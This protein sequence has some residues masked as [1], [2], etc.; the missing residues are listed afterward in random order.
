APETTIVQADTIL[1][2]YNPNENKLTIDVKDKGLA[3]VTKKITSKSDKNIVLSPGLGS[4][5]VSGFVLNMDFA[6]ALE[7]FAYSNDM[8]VEAS[9]DDVFRIKL[10][11]VAE[12]EAQENKPL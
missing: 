9:G 8:V 10:K 1:V 2:D 3:E 11:E 4:R 7:S 5:I 12:K 6:K